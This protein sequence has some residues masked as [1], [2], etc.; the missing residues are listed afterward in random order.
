MRKGD[1]IAFSRFGQSESF[2]LRRS[3]IDLSLISPSSAGM[4]STAGSS[5]SI[6]PCR[7]FNYGEARR[8]CINLQ[9]ERADPLDRVPRPFPSRNLTGYCWRGTACPYPHV[10]PTTLATPTSAAVGAKED[11][12][13]AATT[14]VLEDD[15][16]EE[17]LCSICY[18]TPTQWALLG[19][20][21]PFR[22]FPF[23][24]DG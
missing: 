11:G 17:A 3:P 22:A 21:T 19:A 1:A 23:G 7:W 24:A 14:L 13:T 12:K 10:T 2:W 16:D 8:C 4:D 6:Q 5:S 18:E 15:E 9:P 20:F